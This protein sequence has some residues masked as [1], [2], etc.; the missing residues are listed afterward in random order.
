MS[1]IDPPNSKN[2]PFLRLHAEENQPVEMNS[3]GPAT[4]TNRWTGKF[5][6]PEADPEDVR[7]SHILTKYE[8]S[9][10]EES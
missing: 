10:Q 7:L 9:N 2:Q 8:R 3:T 4:F 5:T 1:P 6:L